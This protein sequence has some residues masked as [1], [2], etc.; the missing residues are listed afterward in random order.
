MYLMETEHGEEGLKP[1]NVEQLRE[2]AYR[3]VDDFVTDYYKPIKSF[4]VLNQVEETERSSRGL[5]PEDERAPP[6]AVCEPLQKMALAEEAP[7]A[8]T[9]TLD[10][11][12]NFTSKRFKNQNEELY[13]EANHA[14]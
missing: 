5:V 2:N 13:G 1:K 10:H 9:E 11:L 14:A 6:N 8:H 3:M 12:F 7:K 4:S